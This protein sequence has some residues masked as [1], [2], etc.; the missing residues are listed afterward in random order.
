MSRM[1][2]LIDQAKAATG[3]SRTGSTA[4]LCLLGEDPAVRT[5]RNWEASAP[6]PPPETATYETGPRIAQA[7]AQ[8]AMREKIT[9]R[10][11]LRE[12]FRYYTERFQVP[13]GKD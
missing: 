13:L 4:L 10:M 2:D 12:E 6:C 3:L 5:M 9:P 1:G 8:M 11:K 7:E